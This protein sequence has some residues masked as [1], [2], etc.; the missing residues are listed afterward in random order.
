MSRHVQTPWAVE[1]ELPVGGRLARLIIQQARGV[2]VGKAVVV[3]AEAD[4]VL[5]QL[6]CPEG[7]VDLAVLVLAVGVDA[8]CCSQQCQNQ[9]DDDGQ[10]DVLEL[11]PGECFKGRRAVGSGACQGGQEHRGRGGQLIS[12]IRAG[13]HS[14]RVHKCCGH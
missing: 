10:D 11:S 7:C 4:V 5:L 12:Y 14:G 2:C 8:T 13:G 1:S 9:C 3:A 6:N